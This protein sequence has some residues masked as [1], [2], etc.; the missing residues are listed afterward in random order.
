[1]DTLTQLRL[2]LTVAANVSLV[3]V[4]VARAARGVDAESVVA[5]LESG[6]IRWAWDFAAP[7]ASCRR[8]VRI[9]VRDLVGSAGPD[10]TQ[11]S[12]IAQVIGATP[13]GRQRAAVIETRWSISAQH[14]QT[15]VAAGLWQEDRV[16]H[17]RYLRRQSLAAFLADRLIQ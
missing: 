1:M 15:L 13:G 2:P 14:I 10:E 5:L 9:W 12:V 3:T 6:T 11:E 8:E 16:G 4:D 17:T 7:G